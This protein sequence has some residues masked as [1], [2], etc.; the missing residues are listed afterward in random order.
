VD[1][2][3]VVTGG[4]AYF[5]SAKLCAFFGIPGTVMC[6]GNLM[7]KDVDEGHATCERE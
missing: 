5:L 1:D 6:T 2:A 7:M 3:K 4:G